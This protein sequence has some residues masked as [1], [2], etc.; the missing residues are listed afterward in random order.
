MSFCP[1]ASWTESPDFQIRLTSQQHG[2]VS[3]VMVACF[4]LIV[5]RRPLVSGP[6]SS[7]VGC[8]KPKVFAHRW[9]G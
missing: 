1:I 6:T 2:S 3:F 5:G 8:P 7:P 9:S 4:H